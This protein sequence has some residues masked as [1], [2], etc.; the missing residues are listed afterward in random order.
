VGPEGLGLLVAVRAG[1]GVLGPLA[2]SAM[3][4]I[5]GYGKLLFFTT[6]LFGVSIVAMGFVPN[7]L[8]ALLVMSV[9]NATGSAVDVLSKTL[10]QAHVPNE[11]RGRSMGAWVVAIGMGPAGQVEIGAVAA[12]LSVALALAINGGITIAVA[13]TVFAAMPRLRRL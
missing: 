12:A 6:V 9:F 1:A 3:G 5:R 4:T 10:I 13:L 8:M 11:E 7:L 2:L